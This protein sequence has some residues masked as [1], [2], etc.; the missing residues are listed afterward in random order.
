MKLIAIL[1]I[2]LITMNPTHINQTSAPLLHYLV[3]E[4]KVKTEK[5]PLIIL[6]H[7]YASNE[8]DLFSFANQ[9]PA[10]FLVISARA[11]YTIGKD[12][13]A[14]Y[15][16]NFINDKPISNKEQAEK[17]R[18]LI[19]QFINQL[20][21]KHAFDT[22]RIYLCGFSQGAIMTDSVGLTNPDQIK[23][24]A[25]MSGMLLEEVKPLIASKE[26][27]KNLRVFMSHGTNDNVLDVHYARESNSYLKQLGL[28]LTFKEYPEGH[29]ISLAMLNDLLT[30]LNKE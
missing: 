19:L 26:K 3:R 23:G 11:P 2:F 24:I 7:G 28:A 25:I 14:W 5:S 15:E 10:N 8:Q 13:Y 6:M 1:L 27:L 18:L 20:K 30:W 9:L 17:S 29:T 21:E 12:S 22:Q 4:P 16:L